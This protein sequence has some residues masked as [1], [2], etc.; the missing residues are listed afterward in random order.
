VPT[1]DDDVRVQLTSMQTALDRLLSSAEPSA[2]GTSGAATTGNVVV[3]RAA[4]MQLRQQ[5]AAA[6]E[7]LN[8]R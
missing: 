1:T 5:L 2:V 6:L 8:R 7:A 4:L 3:D